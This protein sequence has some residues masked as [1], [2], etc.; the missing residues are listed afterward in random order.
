MSKETQM[1]GLVGHDA[2]LQHI[3]SA[4]RA[5]RVSHAY[6]IEGA[7]GSGKKTLMQRPAR[8]AAVRQM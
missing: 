4:V 6:L 1:A 2:V 8:R 3:R 5:G 7:E